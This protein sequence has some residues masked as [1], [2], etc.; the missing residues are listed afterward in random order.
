MIPLSLIWCLH[1]G[2]LD[3]MTY[4]VL[5]ASVAYGVPRTAW[6]LGKHKSSDKDMTWN[7]ETRM[8]E[9]RPVYGKQFGPVKSTLW[10]MGR[11]RSG[12]LVPASSP[13]N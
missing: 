3:F 6:P 5:G 13:G 1:W 4:R 9:K 8:W 2:L 11:H 12:M 7:V 10:G